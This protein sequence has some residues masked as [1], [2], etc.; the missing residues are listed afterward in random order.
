MQLTEQERTIVATRVAALEARTGTQVVTAVVG[1]SDSYP[2]A[3]W[4]AFAIGAGAAALAGVV[5]QLAAG[6]WAAD[7]S[8][9]GHVLVIL[10][11]GAFLALLAILFSPVT[12]RSRRV[13]ST[14]TLATGEIG[15]AHV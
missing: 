15:R 12:S 14:N 8:R 3:P 2:E 4:K 1:K 9:T 13:R 11:C 5:W 7:A 10:G 6:G